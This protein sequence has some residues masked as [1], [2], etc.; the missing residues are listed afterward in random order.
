LRKTNKTFFEAGLSLSSIDELK[1][2]PD[3]SGIF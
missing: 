3:V 1:Q 2:F